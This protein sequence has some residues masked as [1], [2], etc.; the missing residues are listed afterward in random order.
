[1]VNTTA[2]PETIEMIQDGLSVVLDPGFFSV[3]WVFL[4]R[5]EIRDHSSDTSLKAMSFV[6]ESAN[7]LICKDYGI[8]PTTA[9]LEK[10]LREGK[11]S[12]FLTGQKVSLQEY[13]DKASKITSTNA[14]IEMK[15]SMRSEDT[16]ADVVILTGGG[17]SSFKKAAKDLFPRSQVVVPEQSVVSN[18]RGFWYC[19]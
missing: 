4:Q 15:Q 13:I 16:N 5:G 17:A 1:M 7:D 19:G 12:I 18:A 2:N 3:D 6:L 11:S 8:S 14:L 10:A 9:K